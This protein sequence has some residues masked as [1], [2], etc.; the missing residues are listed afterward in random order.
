MPTPEKFDG[1]MD[2]DSV[3]AF[4]ET[5]DNYFD[6]VQLH[7]ANLQA[8]FVYLLLIGPAVDWFRA[9]GFELHRIGWSLLRQS[10][11]AYF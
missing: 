7:D 11:V 8:R 3:R 10:M 2:G 1:K 9:N 6:L 4:V 5:V